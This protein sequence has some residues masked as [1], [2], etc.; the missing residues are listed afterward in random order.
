MAKFAKDTLKVRKRVALLIV[1]FFRLQRRARAS[2]FKE[3]FAADGGTVV[4]EQKY[5]EGDKDFRAQLT[6]IK[7][8]NVEGDFCPRL[9]R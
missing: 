4:L 3:R 1:R 8:A 6:A 2:Y 7:A 5:S 9:L